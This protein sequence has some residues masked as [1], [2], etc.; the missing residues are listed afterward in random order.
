MMAVG[1]ELGES[2]SA[3]ASYYENRIPYFRRTQA[4]DR[5]RDQLLQVT[6]DL[7]MAISDIEE[8]LRA[9]RW[10]AL[11]AL[12][13]HIPPARRAHWRAH[14][15][16]PPPPLLPVLVPTLLPRAS[17]QGRGGRAQVECVDQQGEAAESGE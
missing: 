11:T 4:L 2:A 12:R 14:D 17:A 8:R 1:D 10:A 5:E 3:I 9:A 16:V 13:V 6:T 15:P 7:H